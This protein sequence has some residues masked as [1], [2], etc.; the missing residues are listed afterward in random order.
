[1]WWVGYV[2]LRVVLRVLIGKERRRRVQDILGIHPV[3]A[4]G[5]FY[6][7]MEVYEP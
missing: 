2:F 4:Y 7:N 3:R 5:V 6:G 1:M